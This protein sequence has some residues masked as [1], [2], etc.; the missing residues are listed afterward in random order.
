VNS[1]DPHPA[2]PAEESADNR[3]FPAWERAELPEP[4]PFR[5]S[6]WPKLIGPSLLMAG[7]NIGGGEWLFGPLV[8]AQYGGRVLWLCTLAI[9][10]QV[11]YNLAIQRYSLCCGESV[12]VGFLRTPPGV[13]FWILF[14][15]V[16]DLG[17]Y[18]PYLAANAAVPLAAVILGRLP[19][20]EDD[21][22]VRGLSYALFLS[23]FVPLIFGGK[24]YN[25][26]QRVMVTKLVL[27]LAYLGFIALFWVGL[28]TKWEIASGFY[29]FGA[30]PEGDFNWATLAA[31]AAV[32]GAGGLSNIS[33]SNLVRD[34]GWGMGAVVGAIPSAVG[35]KAI[36]LSHTGKTFEVTPANL[37]RWRGWIGLIHRDQLA[38]WAPACVLGMALPAMISYEFIRGARNIEGNAVA[39]MTAQ[40]LAAR[41]GEIFW[42]LTLLCGFA[43]LYPTQI[44]NL[45]SVSRRWT[46]VIW[47]GVR[48]LHTLEGNKVKFVYYGILLL[49]GLWGLIALRIS[50]NPLVLAIATGVMMNVGLSVSALHVIYVNRRLL[51]RQLR[52]AWVLEAGLVFCS[53]FYGAI[54][55]IALWQE[56]PRLQA[57]LS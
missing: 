18:W 36:E 1:E 25:S 46:D 32:S 3:A 40:S 52:P 35:G 57:W 16:M 9:F 55:G 24:I 2:L 41:H 37:A 10:C 21:A 28:D 39:A 27:V 44:S 33:F 12:L 31:F 7:A 4:P 6:D 26:L 42:F 49:Y 14:Y 13:R 22:L 15:L 5:V 53:L 43:I 19:G 20:A 51:P 48:R 30:L 29:R 11:C 34:K 54:S 50:P 45:D 38:L 47:M 56:L 23:A 8:T 17:T